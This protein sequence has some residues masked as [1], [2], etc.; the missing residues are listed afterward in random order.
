MPTKRSMEESGKTTEKQ[1]GAE[2]IQ[3]KPVVPTAAIKGKEATMSSTTPNSPSTDV[4]QTSNGTAAPFDPVKA[5]KA[6]MEKVNI[7]AKQKYP[8]SMPVIKMN[9]KYKPMEHITKAPNFYKYVPAVYSDAL[10]FDYADTDYELV[11]KDRVF[12][13]ELNSKIVNGTITVSTKVPN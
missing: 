10:N 13:R 12:L 2:E 6:A 8:L 9:L 1:A 7:S 5:I 3:G 4:N 11:E